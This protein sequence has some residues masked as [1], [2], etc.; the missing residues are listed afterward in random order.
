MKTWR[1]WKNRLPGQETLQIPCTNCCR[2]PSCFFVLSLKSLLSGLTTQTLFYLDFH[3]YKHESYLF[4]VISFLIY[5]TF[6]VHVLF[7][8]TLSCQ[9]ISVV[10][11]NLCCRKAKMRCGYFK[12]TVR[13]RASR[14]KIT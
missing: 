7:K 11:N 1:R 9:Y 10:L 4:F 5:L 2:L 6:S 8:D 3:W 12:M 13:Q 14:D